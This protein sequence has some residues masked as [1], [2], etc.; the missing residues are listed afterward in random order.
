MNKITLILALFLV[1]CSNNFNND[2]KDIS[3]YI[4]QT[5]SSC[6]RE[7]RNEYWGDCFT[8]DASNNI[9][10]IALYGEADVEMLGKIN[11][12]LVKAAYLGLD[13]KIANELF[14]SVL[15]DHKILL[16]AIGVNNSSEIAFIHNQIKLKLISTIQSLKNIETIY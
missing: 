13:Y 16:S 2:P 15:E 11:S 4:D 10:F 5:I 12:N 7:T 14:M 1:S 9:Y 3:S 6:Q 8:Q